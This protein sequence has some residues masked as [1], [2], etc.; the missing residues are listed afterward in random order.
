LAHLTVEDLNV[1]DRSA[2]APLSIFEIADAV[3]LLATT[4]NSHGI[5]MAASDGHQH[6]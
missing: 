6:A 1:E 3:W 2:Q 4:K 5:T